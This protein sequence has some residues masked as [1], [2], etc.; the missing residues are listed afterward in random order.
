MTLQRRRAEV[1]RTIRSRGACRESL[2][3]GYMSVR[4]RASALR[5]ATHEILDS[6]VRRHPLWHVGHAYNGHAADVRRAKLPC[7][8]D[9]LRI[10][11]VIRHAEISHATQLSVDVRR[12]TPRAGLP[13]DAD[14]GRRPANVH[15]RICAA[16]RLECIVQPTSQRRSSERKWKGMAA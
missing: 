3:R 13:I 5:F 6:T 7:G 4:L 9:R 1:V 12:V 15:W 8:V 10:G 2:V 14:Q 16:S 11:R